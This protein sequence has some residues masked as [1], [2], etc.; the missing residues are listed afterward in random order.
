MYNNCSFEEYY[1]YINEDVQ[2]WQYLITE[3]K[4]STLKKPDELRVATDAA[5]IKRAETVEVLKYRIHK[6]DPSIYGSGFKMLEYKV[7]AHPTKENDI[8]VG[9]IV[10]NASNKNIKQL[11]CNCK[12]FKFRLWYVYA[13]A[14]FSTYTL[15]DDFKAAVNKD[16]PVLKEPP[17]ITNPTNKQYLCKHLYRVVSDILQM[18]DVQI[19]NL[20]D[21]IDKE[22]KK[23]SNIRSTPHELE[24]T[25]STTAK[26]VNAPIAA[27][28]VTKS[29]AKKW[30]DTPEGQ[31]WKNSEEGKEWEKKSGVEKELPDDARKDI[32]SW[33]KAIFDKEAKAKEEQETKAQKK[34]QKNVS[35]LIK[36]ARKEKEEP[37]T[38]V[39]KGAG[40]K[41]KMTS[42]EQKA[43]YG[44]TAKPK[45]KAEPKPNINKEWRKKTA[46]DQLGANKAVKADS[47][48]PKETKPSTVVKTPKPAKEKKPKAKAGSLG[49]AIN[50]TAKKIREKNPEQFEKNAEANKKKK[51]EKKTALNTLKKTHSG[52]RYK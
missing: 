30:F 48:L 42:A 12:E 24:R 34:K 50:A 5:R 1:D 11:W 44:K 35:S 9:Y 6:A 22:Y 49:S 27:T 43:E 23:A 33:N 3:A 39:D 19:D 31:A 28:T 45:A 32:L 20:E 51:E 18:S 47:A 14:G 21:Q 52:G 36:N 37:K 4:T 8:H 29:L 2:E 13:T 7:L 15:P 17:L 26:K 25:L 38:L 40:S 41:Q 16:Y 10:F 46:V